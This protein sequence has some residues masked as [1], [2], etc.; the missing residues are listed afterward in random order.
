[1]P[2][3]PAGEA[4]EA[5]E[6]LAGVE[7]IAGALTVDG[8]AA[9]IE[10]D[11]DRAPPHLGFGGRLFDHALVLGGTAGL[12]ARVGDERAVIGQAGIL[13]VADGVFVEHA[14]ARLRWTSPTERPW[15]VR[16]KVCMAGGASFGG[17]N[18]C[19]SGAI[20]KPLFR[21]PRFGF[22]LCAS[23]YG[24]TKAAEWQ[25]VSGC[26]LAAPLAAGKGGK[27]FERISWPHVEITGRQ[28]RHS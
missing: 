28:W 1:M 2:R 27:K 15:A 7:I 5:V 14:R 20:G 6:A 19:R 4:V 10:R 17:S 8:E 21:V 25:R 16:G 24:A 22:R 11:V 13:V 3:I 18:D 23:R 26:G 12:G 9:G